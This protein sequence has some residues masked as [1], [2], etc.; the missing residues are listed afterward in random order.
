MEHKIYTDASYSKEADGSVIGFLIVFNSGQKYSY[1]NFLEKVKNTEAEIIASNSAIKYCHDIDPNSSLIVYTDCQK[2]VKNI[3]PN[4]TYKKV[5]G[6]SKKS[7]KDADDLLFNIVDRGTR[8]M[9]RNI[10]RNKN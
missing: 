1:Y 10:V 6:H 2:A 9:L 7:E 5:I 4:V 8:K 3:V